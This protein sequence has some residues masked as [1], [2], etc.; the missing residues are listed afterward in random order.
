[1]GY[2]TVGRVDGLRWERLPYNSEHLGE[3]HLVNSRVRPHEV[4]LAGKLAGLDDWTA[5]LVMG[6]LLG[7]VTWAGYLGRLWAGYG[8][9]DLGKRV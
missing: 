6:G 7:Q 4:R 5:R 1:M 2:W 9:A 8:Q 3:Q